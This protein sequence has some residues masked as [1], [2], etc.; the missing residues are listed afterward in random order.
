[1]TERTLKY[2]VG[3]F[4]VLVHVA[5]LLLV[6]GLYVAGGFDFDQLTT[7]CAIIV[8]MF[9]GYT[10]SIT[11]FIVND[12]FV[13]DDTSRPVS[14]SFVAMSF[15]FPALFA[16]VISGAVLLQASALTFKNFEQFKQALILVEG[17]F[18]VYAGRFV[19]AMF[20]R[21]REQGVAGG[22]P[23]RDARRAGAHP[24]GGG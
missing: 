3:W 11:A 17:L 18:A 20:G 14:G 19:Y 10:T 8:P 21:E 5:V 7:I 22:A 2:R 4:L 24:G 16:L 6:L 12:R 13:G 23:R 15:A 9:A 1:M